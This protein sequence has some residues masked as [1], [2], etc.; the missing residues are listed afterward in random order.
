MKYTNGEQLRQNASGEVE[1][2]Q[3]LPQPKQDS[4]AFDV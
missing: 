3:A 2:A 4:V 1:W